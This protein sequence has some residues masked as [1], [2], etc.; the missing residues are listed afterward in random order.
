MLARSKSESEP[1]VTTSPKKSFGYGF[2]SVLER[3][4][5]DLFQDKLDYRR[6]VTNVPN[7]K[8]PVYNWFKYK[9]GF[10]RQLVVNLLKYWGVPP[11]DIIL[12]PFAG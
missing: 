10:S 8:L 1:H 7:K 3:K 6:L 9:E 5:S 2:R 12:D 4:Y 11:G